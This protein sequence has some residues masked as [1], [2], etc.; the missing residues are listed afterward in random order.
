MK[1]L[2]LLLLA[3]FSLSS[4][5]AQEATEETEELSPEQLEAYMAAMD[6]LEKSF[7]YEYGVIELGNGLATVHVPKGYKYLNKEQSNRVLTDLWGNPPSETMGMLFP[8]DMS[9]LST[10]FSYA[11]EIS[12][13]DEGY[14]DDEDA[15]DLDYEDLLEEMQDAMKEA[16]PERKKMGYPEMNLIGWAASP[17]YDEKNKKL[18]WA[19]EL[20][21][22]GVEENTLNYNIRVLGR[23]GYINLNAIGDIDVLPQ[24]Q[25]DVDQILAAVEFSEGNQYSDFNPDIDKVA[26][27][28]IGGLI[29][30]KVLGKVG[31]LAL[32]AKGWKFIAIGVVALFAA[33]RKKLF[34]GREA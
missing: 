17:F 34:G 7:T 4:V 9:P 10:D 22:E 19:K 23:N 24:V 16:N 30:G 14:I 11:V 2:F 6:S 12:Y 32:L 13:S 3:F 8:E 29:A 1:N 28:G 20:K 27:Y 15:K 21:F 5:I 26:A 31:F 25:K 18:H 33:L